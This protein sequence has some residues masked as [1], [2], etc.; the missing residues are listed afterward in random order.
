MKVRFLCDGESPQFGKFKKGDEKDLAP[1]TERAFIER[2]LAENI[3][4]PKI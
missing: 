2:G 4:S 1:K 3:S